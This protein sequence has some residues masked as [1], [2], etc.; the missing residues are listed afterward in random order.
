MSMKSYMSI[1]FLL[2]ITYNCDLSDDSQQNTNPTLHG[3][4]SLVNVSG[5]LAGVDDDFES[6]IITWDFKT[7]TSEIIVTNS[8]TS[9][10]IHSGYPSGTYSYEVISTEN[11]ITVAIENTSL[12]L[13][14]LTNFQ[15]ILDEGLASDGFQY[16]FNR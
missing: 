10:V 8:N 12:K 3:T 4:W 5:G 13:E 16:T 7:E 9:E 15:L 1:L 14:I 11:D 2:L 6:G